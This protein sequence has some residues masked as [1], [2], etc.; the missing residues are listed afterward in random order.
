[1]KKYLYLDESIDCSYNYENNNQNIEKSILIGNIIN[2]H[3]EKIK[4]DNKAIIK[5]K[6]NI[7][8]EDIYKENIYVIVYKEDNNGTQI[9]IIYQEENI[10][11]EFEKK[12][13]IL[14]IFTYK[15]IFF[16]YDSIHNLDYF[17]KFQLNDTFNIDENVILNKSSISEN[18]YIVDVYKLVN[19]EEFDNM[20]FELI[21]IINKNTNKNKKIEKWEPNRNVNCEFLDFNE[22]KYLYD[23]YDKIIYNIVNR[24]ISLM[25]INFNIKSSGDCGYNLRKIF[26][27]T[28]EHSDGINVEGNK[29]YIPSKRIRNMSLIMALNDDYEGGEFYFRRQN[30]IIR[31][32]KGEIILFPPYW[33]HLHEVFSPLNL[34]YR[35]TINTWLYE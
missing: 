30:K 17:K 32:N 27:P 4:F 24:I 7:L 16:E 12:E 15:N 23:K 14:M 10:K 2:F 29:T 20:S 9:I 26:G 22:N 34:S 33:T 11:L 8:E 13:Q 6:E 31:L 18:I 25:Y 1:M 21:N 19:K 3:N 28:R 5:V 35:Y